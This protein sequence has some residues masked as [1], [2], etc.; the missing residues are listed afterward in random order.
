MNTCMYIKMV[1]SFVSWKSKRGSLKERSKLRNLLLKTPLCIDFF[2]F[3]KSY[4]AFCCFE[5][6]TEDSLKCIE[7][8]P[9][10]S[11][12]ETCIHNYILKTHTHM[13]SS[14]H[15]H[16]SFWMGVLWLI[17]SILLINFA[18]YLWQ[19]RHTHKPLTHK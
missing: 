3:F 17:R 13:V 4:Y 15:P 12:C 16:Q 8:S 14:Y 2:R 1:V 10:Y 7:R 5:A 9:F 18:F 19:R 6:T 11:I